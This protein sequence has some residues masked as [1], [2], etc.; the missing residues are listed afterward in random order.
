MVTAYYIG[1]DRKRYYI[2]SD[3]KK[4]RTLNND[5]DSVQIKGYKIRWSKQQQRYTIKTGRR[6]VYDTDYFDEAVE[7]VI[8][9]G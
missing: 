1:S 9:N 5:N 8:R 2:G 7:W 3:R 6:Q 4:Y